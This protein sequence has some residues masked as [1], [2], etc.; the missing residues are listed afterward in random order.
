MFNLLFGILEKKYDPKGLALQLNITDRAVSKWERGLCAPDISL[1][2]PLS[3]ILGCSVAEIISG[4]KQCQSLS[5]VPSADTD[6]TKT[7]IDYSVKEINRKVSLTKKKI[8]CR[9]NICG[10]NYTGG[11]IFLSIC[12]RLFQYSR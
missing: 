11:G 6:S 4:E 1:L 12:R 7:I 5:P 8:Y 9:H 2:E 10:G 3:Q